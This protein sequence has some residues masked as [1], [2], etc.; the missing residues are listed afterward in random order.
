MRLIVILGLV[1]ALIFV[2][3]QAASTPALVDSPALL[4]LVIAAIIVVLIERK[5]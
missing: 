5:P 3:L 4:A 1:A 2:L